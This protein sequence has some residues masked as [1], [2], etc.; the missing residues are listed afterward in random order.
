MRYSII[1]INYNNREGLE[2]TIK[3]VINLT[4]KDF[5]YIVIDGG[6]TD[7]SVDIIKEYE[8]HITYWVS[9][10]DHGIYH[11]M[12]KGV[13]QSHGDYC[14]FMNSGDIF[15]NNDVLKQI[16][17]IKTK[18]D[19][20]VGKVAIDNNDRILTQPPTG[21]LTMYHL[22]SGAIPHQGAFIRTS[23]LRKNPYDEEYK[24]I[25]DWKFFVQSLV[26]DNCTILYIND[27]I[28]KYDINGI[29]SSNPHLMQEEKEKALKELLPPRILA[30]YQHIKDCECKTSILAPLL[31]KN[32]YIDKLL[33]TLGSFLLKLKKDNRAIWNTKYQS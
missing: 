7:G 13:A 15:Y 12:N 21:E 20:I 9:E 31:R 14:I 26:F 28:A 4:S 11:A 17:T 10:K 2:L 33:Y 1:T 3:S 32:Y 23:L 27:Y 5:E 6:S 8:K 19:I 22:Y 16:A 30:D 29:S 24:I 25:S 18:E